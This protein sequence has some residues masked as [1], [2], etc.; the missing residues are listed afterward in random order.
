M[1]EE[2]IAEFTI[3]ALVERRASPNF[4]SCRAVFQE[5]MDQLASAMR[6]QQLLLMQIQLDYLRTELQHLQIFVGAERTES[7]SLH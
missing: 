5:C 4:G 3:E 7:T 1:T 2:I 6:S